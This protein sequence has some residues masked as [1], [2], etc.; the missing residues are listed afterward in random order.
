[1]FNPKDTDQIL[2]RGAT[3][4]T[5]EEQIDHFKK[6]FPWMKIVG[7]ATPERGIRVLSEAEADA[8]IR[9]Y[10]SAHVAGKCKFVPDSGAASRMFKDIFAGLA[11]VE[12]GETLPENAP[13][14]KLA[15]QIDK[16]AFYT[17]ELFGGKDVKS[18][19]KRVLTDEGLGYGAKP[20]GVIKFHRYAD[21]EVRTA[22]AEHL[23]EAASYMRNADGTCNLV[24]TISPE[25]QTLFEEAL[26]EVQPVFEARY[27]V[28]Y[29]VTFTYQDKA[30]DTIAVDAENNPFRTDDGDLLFR[31]A[32][33][34]A[35][36]YNLD[37]V[38]EELVSIK[39]IDNVAH[40]KLLG[41][42]A[43]YKKVLMGEALK[44][45]DRIFDYL[46]KLDEAPTAQL[47]DE[48]EC[49]LDKELCVKL[50]KAAGEAERVKVLRA[51]LDRPVRVCGMVRNE[52]EPG[53]GPYVIAGK[54]GATSLQIL[55]SVQI[56][57]ADAEAMAAMSRATHFNP[58]D[59]VCCLRD[60]KGGKFD[61]VAHVDPDAGF[62][63]SKSFQGRELKA[64]ELPGLWNGSMSDWNT[65]FVEVPLETFNPVKV[66]L[67]LLRP[68]HQA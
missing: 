42:T 29:H 46:R 47:C 37:K 58:V 16:F 10:E 3:V 23:V 4:Q 8:A 31:P 19:L 63:S 1:M 32:G 28:K 25:H 20:K 24:V 18:I 38:D 61:L 9:Y 22:I 48:I 60:Y 7:P 27:G 2:R 41:T 51:K 53:G 55:E 56:N 65:L 26:A 15:A 12:K 13:A 67:D 35:L 36:I 5:V 45:R 30:T 11:A 34:G 40:E 50:P 14:A 44:I 59:L 17:P 39:N 33:H 54:D 66:V 43:R 49:F 52:G 21:G 68:A 6:G 57:K 62:I 64:L